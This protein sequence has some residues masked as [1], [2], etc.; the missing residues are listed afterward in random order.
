MEAIAYV[1]EPDAEVRARRRYHATEHKKGV[2][3]FEEPLVMATRRTAGDTLGFMFS[4]RQIGRAQYEAGRK[5][6]RTREAQGIGRGRSP[7]ELHEYVD[8]GKGPQDGLTDARKK[9]TSD[10]AAWRRLLGSDGYEIV[11]AVLIEGHSIQ[12]VADSGTSMMP[13]KAA[14]KAMGHV[15]RRQLSVLA[16]A[17][18]FG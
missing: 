12:E 5:Y 8:G 14:T 3:S 2:T 7:S 9:A 4:R 11:E 10:L 18:G 1:P 15:F 17:M 6:Q 13:G 16:R